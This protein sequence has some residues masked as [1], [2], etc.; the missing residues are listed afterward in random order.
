MQK[1]NTLKPGAIRRGS[2]CLPLFL[3]T[4]HLI[5]KVSISAADTQICK[6]ISMPSELFR[7]INKPLSREVGN[8]QVSAYH[9]GNSYLTL[10]PAGG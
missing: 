2:K 4:H 3:L 7:D 6:N 10:V 5:I 1:R 9:D 8:K